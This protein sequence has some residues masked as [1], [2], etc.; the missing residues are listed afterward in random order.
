V[1]V[2]GSLEYGGLNC[3]G[4]TTVATELDS[5]RAGRARRFVASVALGAE[6]CAQPSC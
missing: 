6:D 5:D 1:T 2:K 3:P 4:A